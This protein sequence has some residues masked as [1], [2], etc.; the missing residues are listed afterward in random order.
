MTS[1]L[2]ISFVL[3]LLALRSLQ[4]I[5]STSTTDEGC[6]VEMKRCADGVCRSSCETQMMMF[7]TFCSKFSN[8][9]QCNSG[10]CASSYSDCLVKQN[11]TL[12][13]RTECLDSKMYPKL[14]Q[15]QAMQRRILQSQLRRALLLELQHHRTAALRRRQ[16]RQV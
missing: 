5:S 9:Y 7:P 8:N 11:S 14:T 15:P 16:V 6:E 13:N 1:W 3:H 2:T 10:Y 12:A 4:Q